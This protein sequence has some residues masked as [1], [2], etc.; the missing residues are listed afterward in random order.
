MN[1]DL[2]ILVR[3]N[4]TV[5][6]TA[7]HIHCCLYHVFS[8]EGQG[9]ISMITKGNT[10][11]PSGRCMGIMAGHE[12]RCPLLQMHSRRGPSASSELHSS[13]CLTTNAYTTC[14]IMKPGCEH[15]TVQH[16][17]QVASTAFHIM[18]RDK[19]A[20]LGSRHTLFSARRISRLF[21]VYTL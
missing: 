3:L 2:H 14:N 5:R 6:A 17:R 19:V 20:R 9:C 1:T 18:I 13:P 16:Q 10:H 11:C 15:R 7:C 21:V 4:T 12:S 8:P